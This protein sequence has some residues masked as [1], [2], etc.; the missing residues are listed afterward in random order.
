MLIPAAGNAG[1]DVRDSIV[2]SATK[3][4]LV[5]IFDHLDT[6]I[7]LLVVGVIASSSGSCHPILA[8]SEVVGAG[9]GA[10]V[11]CA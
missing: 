8:L 10:C 4:V 3:H 1:A 5:E 7:V 11:P 6:K 2:R 9:L